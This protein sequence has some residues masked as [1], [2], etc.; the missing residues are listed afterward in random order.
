MKVN[1]LTE[2]VARELLQNLYEGAVMDALVKKEEL[3]PK[4]V[5]T[6]RGGA[7]DPSYLIPIKNGYF[8]GKEVEANIYND[9]LDEITLLFQKL[10]AELEDHKQGAQVEVD[11]GDEARKEIAKLKARVAELEQIISDCKRI[12]RE[13]IGEN[14]DPHCRED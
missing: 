11:L 4:V 6:R 8:V 13:G 12:G 7:D 3:P 14:N 9:L 10:K 2:A 1:K 5:D